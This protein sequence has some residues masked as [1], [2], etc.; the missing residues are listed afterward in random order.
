MPRGHLPVRSYLAVPVKGRAG[1]VIGGLFFGHSDVG[2]FTENHERV[3]IG[4]ASWASVALEN[5]R[6]FS[7][8]RRRVASRTTSWRASPTNCVRRSMRSS[9]TR[10]CCGRACSPRTGTTKAI[11]TIERNATSLAQ[12]I[13]DVLDISRIISGKIRLNV[14]SVDFPDIVRSAI[15]AV[16]P[17]ADAKNIRIESVLDPQASP[18][19][20][21]P[22]GCSRSC[23]TCCRMPS[24]SP[25]RAARCRFVL[26][27]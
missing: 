4:I 3:A 17:A 16:I 14:Q 10:A 13:E 23:G 2:R 5:A 15:D 24:S 22:S 27:E 12:I 8:S 9:D 26:N 7:A 6:M 11:E 25:T 21:D 18:I 19:S 20:G 1:D